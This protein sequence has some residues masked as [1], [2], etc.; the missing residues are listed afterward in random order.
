MR[1]ERESKTT[2]DLLLSPGTEKTEENSPSDRKTYPVF[3]IRV[4]NF[5]VTRKDL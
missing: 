2:K 5:E 3:T 1:C 4:V